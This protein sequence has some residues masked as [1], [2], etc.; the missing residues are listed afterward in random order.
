[1]NDPYEVLGVPR[2]A[3][4]E[5]IKKATGIWPGNIIRT[6]IMTALWPIW[7]RRR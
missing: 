4:D 3:T 5:E 1:M 2:T 7:R 6:I